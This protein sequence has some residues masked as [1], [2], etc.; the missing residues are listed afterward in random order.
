VDSQSAILIILA[1]T[2][3]NP[4]NLS[5]FSVLVTALMYL[6]FGVLLFFYPVEFLKKA[7]IFLDHPV[8][9]MEA[10]S[11]YGGLEIG[12]GLFLIYSYIQFEPKVSLVMGIFLLSFT[13]IGRLYGMFVDS[14]WSSYLLYALIIEG[15]VLGLNLV[16][17]LRLGVRN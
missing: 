9:I 13:L 7:K 6:G 16:S 10:R 11:F 3:D 17:Y 8:G 12:L 1:T 14:A 4:M 15:V 2:I 5:L